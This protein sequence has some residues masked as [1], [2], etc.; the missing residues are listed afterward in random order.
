M[1][2]DEAQIETAKLNLDYARIRSPIDGVAGV[3]QVDPGNLVHA[4]DANGL[5][6]IT[7]LDPGGAVLHAA[8]GRAAAA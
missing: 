3:R 8:R 2:A 7:Q 4:T 5:V 6:V 1:H